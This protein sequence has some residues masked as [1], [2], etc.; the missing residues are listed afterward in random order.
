MPGK[1]T[2]TTLTSDYT[3]LRRLQDEWEL[4]N[5]IVGP[6]LMTLFRSRLP[7]GLLESRLLAEH[8]GQTVRVTGVVAASRHSPMVDGRDM[9]FITLEDEWGLIEVTLFPGTCSPVPYLSL[10]PYIATGTVEEQHGVVS[11]TARS[12]RRAFED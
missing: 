10:G 7:R 8:I 12:F 4:F 5:F 9:Q 1:R 3:P 11:V 2:L 6:P